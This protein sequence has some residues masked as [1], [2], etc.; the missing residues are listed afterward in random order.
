MPLTARQKHLAMISA[1]IGA[2]FLLT[3]LCYWPS[4]GGPFVFDDI[5]NLEIM[6][7]GGGLASLDSYIEFVFS[8]QASTLGRP[9]SLLSFTLDGQ[10]CV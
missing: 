7:K 4:L 2:A 1:G 9:L 10:T 3:V 6:G 5:P 8:A